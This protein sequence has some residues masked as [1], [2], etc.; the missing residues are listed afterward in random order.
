[1]RAYQI[2]TMGDVSGLKQVELP[3]PTAG[4]GEVVVQVRACSL[5]Y[6]D[7]MIIRGHYNPK[8]EV[9]RIPLSDCSGEIVEVGPAGLR[10]DIPLDQ[11]LQPGAR[12]QLREGCDHTVSTC[13]ARFANAVNFQGEP[14]LPGNDLLARYAVPAA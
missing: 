9:P 12:A 5:N 1:M 10:L 14:F 11:D 8:M 3:K 7:L 4:P 6:R 13:A 2:E